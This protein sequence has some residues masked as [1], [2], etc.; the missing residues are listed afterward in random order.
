MLIVCPNCSTSYAIEAASLGAA[1]RTVR[2]ARCKATWFAES[3]VPTP[4]RAVAP[5]RG[6][7]TEGAFTGVLRPDQPVN[8]PSGVESAEPGQAP[9]PE[10]DPNTAPPVIPAAIAD[11]PSVVPAMDPQA[12]S[13]S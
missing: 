3:S 2:C 10:N 5:D 4:E 1:G 12:H 8:A 11:A 7:E 13:D 6:S 9:A